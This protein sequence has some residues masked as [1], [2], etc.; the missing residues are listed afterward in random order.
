MLFSIEMIIIS[1]VNTLYG[2]FQA[3]E[4]G[5]YHGICVSLMNS[6]T[7]IFILISIYTDLGLKGVTFAYILANLI[8]FK[9]CRNHF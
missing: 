3:F 1:Y 6:M 9:P 8:N 4:K 2:T 7:L 5:K